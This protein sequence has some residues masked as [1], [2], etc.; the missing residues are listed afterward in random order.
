MKV[1]L[2]NPFLSTGVYL[3]S[4]IRVVKGPYLTLAVLAAPLI[5]RGHQVEILDLSIEEDPLQKLRKVL[6][7]FP[8]D[9]VG[10]TFATPSY[11][12][13][14]TISK[15]VRKESN[16]IIVGGG[17]H[18]STMPE[19][20]LLNSDLDIV[21]VGEGDFTLAEI[22]SNKELNSIE[23]ICYKSGGNI[24]SNPPR[25]YL[26]DLDILSY[27]AWKF[28]DIKRY[29]MGKALWRKSLIGPIETSRGCFFKCIYCNKAAF[30]DTFR[31]KSP[32]RVVDEIEYLLD[33][34]FEEIHFWDDNFTAN[35]SRAKAI[36]DLIR[37][38]GLK[39]PWLL[40]N[41]IRADSIDEEFLKEAYKAGCYRIHFGVESGDQGI[42][43]NISKNQTLEQVEWAF[44]AARRIGLETAAYF[45]FGFPGETER[46]IRKTIDFARELK[47]DLTRV[48]IAIPY[49]GTPFYNEWLEK[50]YI[51]SRDW[52]KYTFHSK[53]TGIY[54]H[55]TLDTEMIWRYY[56]IFYR[57]FYLRIGYT[58]RRMKKGIIRGHLFYDLNY[59]LNTF[60]RPNKAVK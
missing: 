45:V 47:P 19:E 13:M 10:I 20:V 22:V 39:F 1:L 3:N 59:F 16:S 41:G 56:N 18:A 40:A 21:V 33:M 32:E 46:T 52:S 48:A 57:K 29:R 15:I 11:N 51:K 12:E 26:K 34:G 17:P 27:P 55:P 60:Y 37:K 6:R 35:L 24:I 54:D 14:L 2:I 44:Q 50:G 43:D 58:L 49:P 38:R 30:G 7:G 25:P 9:Y 42:L 4:K 53:P 28:C 31:V 23:G 8:P 36:C 5:E